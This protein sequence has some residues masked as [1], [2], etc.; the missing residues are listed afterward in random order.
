ME[1]RTFRVLVVG[2]L[3]VAALI[4]IGLATYLLGGD[5]PAEQAGA[6][7]QIDFETGPERSFEP[8][9]VL[10][11]AWGEGDTEIWPDPATVGAT[12]DG[13][14]VTDEGD[15]VVADHPSW[16]VGARVRRFSSDGVL[17]RTWLTPS[18]SVFFQPFGTGIMYVTA[19]QGGP[20]EH[21]EL[22]SEDGS[23]VTSFPIPPE[24][25]SAALYRAGDFI[26]V[27]SDVAQLA[28][29]PK[30]MRIEPLAYPVVALQTDGPI[31]VPDPQPS[32]G[33][34][35]DTAG[36]PYQRLLESDSWL[37]TPDSTQTVT[38]ADGRAVRIPGVSTVVGVDGEVVWM[39][40]PRT[41]ATDT[42]LER[43]G[44][45]YGVSAEAEVMATRV[46]G[47]FVAREIVPWTPLLQDAHP[48][49]FVRRDALWLLNAD[50]DGL[51][52]VRYEAVER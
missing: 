13:F 19:K 48:R 23:V 14:A 41:T 11:L 34:G 5:A 6:V 33:A 42:R 18:G 16:H 15:M 1:R 45:P 10:R 4:G 3:S 8:T 28:D 50:P 2:A 43:A 12:I 17:E 25:N 52:V 51:S 9:E 47:T 27:T 37:V 30:A 29:Q 35:A 32:P 36:G 40:M 20:Q 38:L 7:P 46:D 31:A 21:V 39:V 24:I 44:W 22:M 26:V 49:L